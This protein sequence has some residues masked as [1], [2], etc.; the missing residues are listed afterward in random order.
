[1]SATTFP[2][3][4][5]ISGSG[6]PDFLASIARELSGGLDLPAYYDNLRASYTDLRDYFADLRDVYDRQHPAWPPEP[7]IDPTNPTRWMQPVDWVP[8]DGWSYV[9]VAPERPGMMSCEV[10]GNPLE[11]AAKGRPR[12]TCSDACRKVLS[13]QRRA[14]TA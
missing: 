8:G 11:L 13:R 2:T 3:T 9:T 1:M 4:P 6:L 10:C 12:R 5:S 14:A 7:T